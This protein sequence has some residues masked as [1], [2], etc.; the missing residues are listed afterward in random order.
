MNDTIPSAEFD[1]LLVFLAVAEER[2]FR[3]A[4]RRLGVT[5]SAVSQTVRALE[6]RI[7]VALLMRTTRSVGL[8]EAGERLLEQ[9]R[10]AARLL[11]QGIESARSLAGS[12]SGTLR[13]NVPR[14]SI[15]FL[16]DRLA[17]EFLAAYP[18]IRLEL[19]G[20]DRLVDIVAQ[21]CDAGVRVSSYVYADMVAVPLTP[22][23]PYVVVGSPAL[24]DRVGRPG[25]PGDIQGLP[26]VLFRQ[27]D[28][29]LDEW[30]FLVSG[31]RVVV[32]AQGPLIMDDVAACVHAA[33]HGAGLFRTPRS[34][35]TR[36]IHSGLLEV[37]LDAY[38]FQFPGL[39]LYFP[40][41]DAVLPKLRAFIDFAARHAKESLVQARLARG[42]APV[43]TRSAPL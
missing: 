34:L 22:A 5:P 28:L 40:G 41:R 8:T 25:A 3:S 14:A 17:L 33:V 21:G 9:L 23:E 26:C 1:G 38:A 36:E 10:P 15:V 37:V 6:R 7:G 16:A 29:L 18:G 35:V 4:A 39:S 32:Q 30:E 19:I 43:R 24:L 2:G 11:I 20:D 27:A 12:L 31:E 42:D 13:I